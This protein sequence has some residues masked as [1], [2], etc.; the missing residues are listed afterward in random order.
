MNKVEIWES[1]RACPVDIYL[2][3][4]ACGIKSLVPLTLGE[5]HDCGTDRTIWTAILRKHH[6]QPPFDTC[7]MWS[8]PCPGSAKS[9]RIEIRSSQLQSFNGNDDICIWN[10]FNDLGNPRHQIQA[11]FQ[12]IIAASPFDSCEQDGQVHSQHICSW[13][14]KTIGITAYCSLLLRYS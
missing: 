6:S 8:N 9:K 10:Y 2:G 1:Q 13:T 4:T 3:A 7:E 12:N 14:T 5:R 11:P